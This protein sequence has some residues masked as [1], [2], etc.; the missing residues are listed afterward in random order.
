MSVLDRLSHGQLG[1]SQ[2][3]AQGALVAHK[4][5]VVVDL[6][7]QANATLLKHLDT[8]EQVRLLGT[9]WVVAYDSD[10][11]GCIANSTNDEALLME[12]LFATQLWALDGGSVMMR[13][14]K[15]ADRTDIDFLA[16][17]RRYEDG[18]M[19]VVMDAKG[20]ETKLHMYRL[21]R[22]RGGFRTFI[23]MH[24]VY[25][26]LR[27]TCFKGAPSKWTYEGFSRWDKMLAA[28]F[29]FEG[30]MLLPV[31]GLTLQSALSSS[32]RFLPT[33][34]CLLLALVVLL[35]RW[36]TLP[37][38]KGGLRDEESKVRAGRLLEAL[39]IA[40]HDN[41][42]SWSMDIDLDADWMPKF[43][44]PPIRSAPDVLRIDSGRGVGLAHWGSQVDAAILPRDHPLHPW[45]RVVSSSLDIRVVFL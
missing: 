8:F 42:E 45:W 24:S 13:S 12:D 25:N 29:N 28:T 11:Y 9:S 1:R 14:G 18:E 4:G 19:T 5:R 33:P 26:A 23:C 16:L 37:G 30:H 34:A 22:A 2:D 43:P 17:Q 36:S 3:V 41:G 10:G 20:D 32:S 6:D 39:L 21:L 38:P 35:V 31:G 27:L 44:R 15:G 7:T 40:C